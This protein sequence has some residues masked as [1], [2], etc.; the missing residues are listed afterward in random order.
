MQ[1]LYATVL[2]EF[3]RDL[4]S[5]ELSTVS[6][7][8]QSKEAVHDDDKKLI[9]AIQQTA[10]NAAEFFWLPAV[11]ARNVRLTTA[12]SSNCTY[13][14]LAVQLRMLRES[15]EDE[16]KNRLVLFMPAGQAVHYYAGIRLL[17]G[18]RRQ[19]IPSA[20]C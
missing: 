14:E 16:L 13:S 6:L 5:F 15:L 18:W 11:T 10:Q 8:D 7:K 2:C 9:T 1:Q 17:G 4:T 3:V 12:L 19:S 20:R